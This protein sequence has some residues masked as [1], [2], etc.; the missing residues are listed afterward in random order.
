MIRLPRTDLLIKKSRVVSGEEDYDNDT[1]G[2]RTQLFLEALQDA[3]DYIHL[4]LVNEKKEAFAAYKDVTITSSTESIPVPTDAFSDNLVYIVYYSA[5]DSSGCF[6]E[7]GTMYQRVSPICEGRPCE[8]F[9]DGGNI[10]FDRKPTSGVMR[11]RYEKM[12]DRLELRRGQILSSAGT[13]PT[14]TSITIDTNEGTF[15]NENDWIDSEPEY[16]TIND[17]D[18]VLLM[19]NIPFSSYDP[20]TGTITLDGGF[21]AESDETCPVGAWVLFGQSSTTHSKLPSVTQ[22][23]FK[24]YMKSIAF[25]ARSADEFTQ[26]NPRMLGFLEQIAEVYSQLPSGFMG[27]PRR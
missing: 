9:V 23:Y 17:R 18:G 8:Y 12:I 13:L 14:L 4:F 24:E 21:S 20:S 5:S 22:V 26:S 25:E 3:S 7:L 2:L 27:I 10:Y 1:Y 15:Y 16:L 19:K 6:D 11:I